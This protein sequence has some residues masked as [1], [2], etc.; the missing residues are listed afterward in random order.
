MQRNYS[1]LNPQELEQIEQ[2]M[3]G[4]SLS[5]FE[6]I[7]STNSWLM[8]N[9][10]CGDICIS[11]TQ[12]LGRGRRGNTWVSPKSGNIY[13]SLCWC[14]EKITE[15][16]SLLGLVVG[17]AIAEALKDSGLTQHGVKWPNDIF[18]QRKKMGGVLIETVGQTGKVVIGVGLNINMPV[19][20]VDKIDQ[21]FVSLDDALSAKPETKN[22]DISRVDLICKLIKCF[23]LALKDFPE[24][25]FSVFNEAWE[26][27]DILQ[28]E[29]VS[30]SI[31]N[32]EIRG[33]VVGI[34]HDGR[35][36]IFSNSGWEAGEVTYY[37][38]AEIKLHKNER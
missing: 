38:S 17:V 22:T 9:G 21:Q 1:S 32:M 28:G 30:F 8:D 13:F 7:D 26:S 25:S 31:Q 20:I 15:N 27:W 12:S 3:N 6:S 37:S 14:F 24:M 29:L 10:R 23:N 35:I 34:D 33:K 16:W 5:H 11:E 19:D 2:A 36:G 18:W 4:G